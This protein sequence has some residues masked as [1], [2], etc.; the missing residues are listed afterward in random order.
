MRLETWTITPSSTPSHFEGHGG[1]VQ[2]RD[3]VKDQAAHAARDAKVGAVSAR[4][5]AKYV[6]FVMTM[7]VRSTTKMPAAS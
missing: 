2:C 3:E 4:R 5:A 1:E 6:S 7:Y